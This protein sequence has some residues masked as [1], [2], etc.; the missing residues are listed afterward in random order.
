MP[1]ARTGVAG[2]GIHNSPIAPRDEYISYGLADG[3]S[4]RDR[5]HVRLAL[6]S[7]I[8]N[9]GHVIE[10]FGFL[11]DRSGNLDRV[12][13]GQLVNDVDRRFVVARNPLSKLCAGRDLN[14]IGETANDL[15]ERLYL[16]VAITARDHQ[17]GR[18]PQGL[19]AAFGRAARNRVVKILKIGFCLSHPSILNRDK[20]ECITAADASS[21]VRGF[22]KIGNQ[23]L[24]AKIL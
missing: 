11:Q 19:G 7:G 21:G 24:Y 2:H 12:V 8:R 3:P 9:Q 18:M 16:F 14:L 22:G 5:E 23:G 1:D 6:R 15:A 20:H 4:L 17:I 13:E 10:L